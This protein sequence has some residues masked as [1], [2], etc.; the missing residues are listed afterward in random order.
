[1]A[2][3]AC[4]TQ[5]TQFLLTR[6]RFS[7]LIRVSP[8]NFVQLKTRFSV[9]SGAEFFPVPENRHSTASFRGSGKS[10]GLFGGSQSLRRKS[11]DDFWVT[12]AAADDADGY[13]IDVSDGS[14][15]CQFLQSPVWVSRN[16][17][18]VFCFFANLCLN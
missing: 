11:S 12:K 1:M 2:S 3:I 13:E 8:S 6:S 10:F 9:T 15:L 14:E 5:A 17:I 16:S 18:C 7:P 4:S